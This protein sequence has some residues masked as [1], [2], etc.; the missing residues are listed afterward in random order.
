[1]CNVLYSIVAINTRL[2]SIC[3]IWILSQI[4]LLLAILVC[5]VFVSYD[6]MSRIALLLSKLVW[7]AFVS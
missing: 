5:S 3:L 1:M 4:V 6:V 2:F 7:S